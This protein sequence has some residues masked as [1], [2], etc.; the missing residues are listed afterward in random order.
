MAA[1]WRGSGGLTCSID[2]HS[3]KKDHATMT[4]TGSPSLAPIY[5]SLIE[6]HGDVL[7]ESRRVAEETARE[8][9]QALDW[10]DLRTH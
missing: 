8:A 1:E 3:R 2:P 10:R 7:A 6:E 4:T 9:D 5:D